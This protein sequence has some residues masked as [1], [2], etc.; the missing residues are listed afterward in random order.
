M[1]TLSQTGETSAQNTEVAHTEEEEEFAKKL[2]MFNAK[3]QADEVMKRTKLPKTW[4]SHL[5]RISNIKKDFD[6]TKDSN[7]AYSKIITNTTSNDKAKYLINIVEE[8]ITEAEQAKTKTSEILTTLETKV[9]EMSEEELGNNEDLRNEALEIIG[10]EAADLKNHYMARKRDEME[11]RQT[12][13]N[14]LWMQPIKIKVL[15]RSQ[16]RSGNV[17]TGE[18]L[19]R[20]EVDLYMAP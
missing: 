19:E 11:S 14:T 5:R 8:E 16:K 3:L 15:R 12:E 18:A 1:G 20:V 7:L 6:K 13:E 9:E 4:M 10:T 2:H 17:T